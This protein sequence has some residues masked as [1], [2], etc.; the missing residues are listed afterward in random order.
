MIDLHFHSCAISA[1]L[2]IEAMMKLSNTQVNI[3]SLYK[4]Y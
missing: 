2:M 3:P 1:K 4:C